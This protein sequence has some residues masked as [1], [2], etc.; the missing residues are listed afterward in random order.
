LYLINDKNEII[1]NP[2]ELNKV[3][4]TFSIPSF[5]HFKEQYFTHYFCSGDLYFY[6]RLNVL[7]DIKAQLLDSRTMS[8]YVDNL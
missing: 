3:I 8:K 6:K 1:D 4:E 2:K 5:K 7:G